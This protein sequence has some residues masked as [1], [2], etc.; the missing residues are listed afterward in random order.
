MVHV[1]GRIDD[2]S[3]RQ[4]VKFERHLA[5][6]HQLHMKQAKALLIQRAQVRRLSDIISREHKASSCSNSATFHDIS[7]FL[8]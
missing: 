5:E 4:T 2:K 1:C 7:D 3:R 6:D 8:S